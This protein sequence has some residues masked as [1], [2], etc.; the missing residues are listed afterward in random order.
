MGYFTLNPGVVLIPVNP[1]VI[2]LGGH[3]KAIIVA[4]GGWF[5]GGTFQGQSREIT[6]RGL[7]RKKLLAAQGEAVCEG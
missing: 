1:V 4:A 3:H 2:Q 6:S 5:R 7:K